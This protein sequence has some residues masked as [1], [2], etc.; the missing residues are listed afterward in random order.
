ME[1]KSEISKV[2][3]SMENRESLGQHNWLST[4]EFILR[5]CGMEKIWLNSDTI[6]N[7]SVAHKCSVILKNKFVDY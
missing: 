2:V 4:V 6:K 5:Y 3:S 7:V 1:K